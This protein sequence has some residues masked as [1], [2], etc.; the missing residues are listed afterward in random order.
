M[1]SHRSTH[2][3]RVRREATKLRRQG[4]KVQADLSGYDTPRPIGQGKRVPDIVATQG[5]RMKIIEVE[6]PATVNTHA[7][8]HTTFRR[9]AAQR[10]N[11]E[12]QLIITWPRRA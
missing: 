8:Q 7:E 4:W 9:S 1:N 3:N 6:T 2:D 12:F 5:S 11:A 10:A